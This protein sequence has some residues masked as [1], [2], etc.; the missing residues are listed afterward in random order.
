MLGRTLFSAALLNATLLASTITGRTITPG[1]I[2]FTSPDP[3]TTPVN[4]SS[5]A[6]IQWG[7][8][9][10]KNGNWTVTVQA[11]S[12]VMTG[13]PSVPI[14]AIRFQCTSFNA[15]T[16]GQG[17]CASGSFP[18]STASQTVASGNREGTGGTNTATVVFT[19]T[20]AWKYPAS[21]SCSIQLTYTITAA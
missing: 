17:N 13:C 9:G 20:D 2:T 8:T 1:T 7:M 12:S 6:T 14:S 3:D 21:T 11:P 18:L 4:G 16:G 19:F 5:S 15:E 10:N